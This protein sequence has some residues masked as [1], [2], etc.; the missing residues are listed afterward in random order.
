MS[1]VT[2]LLDGLSSLPLPLLAVAGGLL[3][4]AECSIGLGV[5][6]PGETGVLIAALAVDDATGFV[7]LA[8]AVAVGAAAGDSAGYLIGPPL[9]YAAAGQP[10]GSPRPKRFV[11]PGRRPATAARAQSGVRS[12]V[13][14]GRAS[15]SPGGLRHRAARSCRTG[16]SGQPAWPAP[17]SERRPRHGRH[18]RRDFGPRG[19][20]PHSDRWRGTADTCTGSH[21]TSTVAATASPSSRAEP[22]VSTHQAGPTSV[23]SSPRRSA[24][25]GRPVHKPGPVGP[26][27]QLGPVPQVE[28]GQDLGYVVAYRSLAQ[29]QRAGDLG[30]AGPGGD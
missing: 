18:A 1:W 24:R 27:R 6:V 16:A 2:D 4:S 10:T 12:P 29:K 11:G 20:G 30:V 23:L 8:V 15:R 13:D 14:A 22:G 7:V 19:R 26:G 28:L 21:S 3:A 17:R 25:S 5:V 9:R